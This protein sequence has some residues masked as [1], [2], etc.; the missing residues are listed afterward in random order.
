VAVFVY[1]LFDFFRFDVVLRNVLDIV[2]IPLRF[3]HLEPH[4]RELPRRQMPG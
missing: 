2:V 3:Q 4:A 1:N